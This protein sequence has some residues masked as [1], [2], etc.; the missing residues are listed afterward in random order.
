MFEKRNQA[1]NK[2]SFVFK[3][4]EISVFVKF[5]ASAEGVDEILLK[6]TV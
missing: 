2:H 3:R 4:L 1:E 5:H 6:L